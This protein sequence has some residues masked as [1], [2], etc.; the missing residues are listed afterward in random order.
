MKI[1]KSVFKLAIVANRLVETVAHLENVLIIFRDSVIKI[2][3]K[4]RSISP[5]DHE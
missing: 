1:R 2:K 5:W 4:S 3:Q